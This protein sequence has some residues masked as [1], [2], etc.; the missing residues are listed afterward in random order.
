MTSV[1][2]IYAMATILCKGR[3]GF[4]SSYSSSSRETKA[5]N[6]LEKKTPE[7]KAVEECGLLA[8]IPFSTRSRPACLG[9]ALLK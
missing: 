3:K 4:I 8:S 7:V 9:M 5:M 6:D 2:V 1:A